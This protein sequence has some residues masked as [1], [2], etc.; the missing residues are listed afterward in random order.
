MSYKVARNEH[1]R[2][3]IA[4]TGEPSYCHALVAAPPTREPELDTDVWLVM[5]F[6]VW[7]IPDNI[8]IQTALDVTKH[9]DGKINLGLRP[10]DDWEE[11][12]AWG[13]GL[14]GDG[15]SPLWVLFRDGEVLMTRN[16]ILTIDELVEAIGINVQK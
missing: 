2:P 16:G 4:L 12:G 7:S 11:L 15:S 14:E 9:F 10:F 3:G 13:P 6:A 8:A 1:G 5:A